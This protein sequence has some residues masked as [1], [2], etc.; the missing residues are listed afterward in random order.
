VKKSI[1]K[2]CFCK[3]D[4]SIFAFGLEKRKDESYNRHS[5]YYSPAAAHW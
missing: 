4:T 2:V 1:G 3:K 5:T